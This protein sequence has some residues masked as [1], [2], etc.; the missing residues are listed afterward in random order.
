MWFAMAKQMRKVD[1][2]TDEANALVSVLARDPLT[3]YIFSSFAF[4]RLIEYFYIPG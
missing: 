3:P 4:A 1:E 2:P